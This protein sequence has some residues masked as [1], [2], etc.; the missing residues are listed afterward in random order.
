MSE[1]EKKKRALQRVCDRRGI[2]DTSR[3]MVE[4]LRVCYGYDYAIK[5]AKDWP[6][7]ALQS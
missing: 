2:K 4:I 5:A 1:A 6:I 3:A 7:G